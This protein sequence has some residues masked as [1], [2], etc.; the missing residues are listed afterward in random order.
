[1][2]L[3]I[4]EFAINKIV[5]R[6]AVEYEASLRAGKPKILNTGRESKRDLP[7]KLD[8]ILSQVSGKRRKPG[9]R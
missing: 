9:R 4:D 1:M 6:T 3:E 8:A 2:S 5:C 7:R